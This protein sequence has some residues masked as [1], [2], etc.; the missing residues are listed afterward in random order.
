MRA[1]PKEI[2]TLEVFVYVRDA[3]GLVYNQLRTLPGDLHTIPARSELPFVTPPNAAE[4]C[5]Y[6]LFSRFIDGPEP[7][8][9]D[10]GPSDASDAQSGD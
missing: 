1:G 4:F 10:G 6:D 5:S 2:N 3:N 8:M 7:P 9:P